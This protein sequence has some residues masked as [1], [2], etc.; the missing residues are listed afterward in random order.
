MNVAC[1][2]TPAPTIAG[3]LSQHRSSRCC[4]DNL[5]LPGRSVSVP[6]AVIDLSCAR[7]PP[8]KWPP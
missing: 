1:H 6:F 7:R 8:T 2:V 4:D 3:L 5:D